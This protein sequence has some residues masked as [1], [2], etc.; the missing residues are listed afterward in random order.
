[1]PVMLHT[2]LS[3]VNKDK[4]FWPGW[5]SDSSVAC[6]LNQHAFFNR[7]C[8]LVFHIEYR[9]HCIYVEVQAF[10]H[11]YKPILLLSNHLFFSHCLFSF[12]L[13]CLNLIL[14]PS[15]AS[16]TNANADF[17]HFDAFTS[18]S[19]STG[20][21]PSAAQTPFHPSDTG[22]ANPTHW[23]K[24]KLLQLRTQTYWDCTNGLTTDILFTFSRLSAMFPVCFFCIV[25]HIL[26][27]QSFIYMLCS[28][29]SCQRCLCTICLHS[30]FQQNKK[31]LQNP[32]WFINLLQVDTYFYFVRVQLID[33][34]RSVKHKVNVIKF[35]ASQT[36]T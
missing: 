27:F 2:V 16:N 17:A 33:L 20:G 9:I 36:Q 7:L 3:F 31:I 15:S 32:V 28:F 19:G 4:E 35:W 18:H 10:C 24:S 21:F 5:A 13:V 14:T 6:L 11:M 22:R 8:V 34:S 12:F 25:M 30:V 1:M 23:T 29:I 26:C